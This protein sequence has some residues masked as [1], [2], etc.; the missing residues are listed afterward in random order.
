MCPGRREFWLEGTRRERTARW[1]REAGQASVG[2]GRKNETHGCFLAVIP[3]QSVKNRHMHARSQWRFSC[4]R[5]RERPHIRD[6]EN[7]TF[8]KAVRSLP[9]SR[10]HLNP[11]GDSRKQSYSCAF[12][13]R[14]F[15]FQVT[16]Q[17]QVQTSTCCQSSRLTEPVYLL[18]LNGWLQTSG[19]TFNTVT[20]KYTQNRWQEAIW[21]TPNTLPPNISTRKY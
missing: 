21:T 7:T 1:T 9:G 17:R 14:R 10:I 13:C 16:K 18:I 11:S 15:W 8:L 4:S 6:A 12:F 20:V 2:W 19:D 5:K 3:K